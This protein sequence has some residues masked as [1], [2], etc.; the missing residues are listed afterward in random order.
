[1]TA[2]TAEVTDILELQLRE[3]LRIIPPKRP[4]NQ[5]GNAEEDDALERLKKLLADTKQM[6]RQ[7]EA[8]VASMRNPPD[9]YRN[10]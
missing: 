1:M 7:A 4:V 5:P 6:V 8:L 10:T 9:F 3:S 2:P